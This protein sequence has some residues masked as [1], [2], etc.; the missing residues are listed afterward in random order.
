MIYLYN[1][2]NLDSF[3]SSYPIYM[4]VSTPL[5]AELVFNEMTYIKVKLS[6]DVICLHLLNN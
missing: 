2:F 1:Y 6:Q 4:P 5:D 3:S